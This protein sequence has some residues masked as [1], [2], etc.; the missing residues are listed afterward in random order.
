MHETICEDPPGVICVDF[1]F[2]DLLVFRI[3]RALRMMFIYRSVNLVSKTFPVFPL[4]ASNFMSRI[5]SVLRNVLLN[6]CVIFMFCSI[7]IPNLH[8]YRSAVR[9]SVVIRSVIGGVW[10]EHALQIALARRRATRVASSKRFTALFITSSLTSYF[11]PSTNLSHVSP[12][13]MSGKARVMLQKLVICFVTE[14]LLVQLP[15]PVPGPSNVVLWHEV[16]NQRL[17]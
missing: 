11:R 6:L 1:S 14:E 13:V 12:S 17:F 15:K 10:F 16:F 4:M 3:L 7:I 9:S 5:T 8:S 2:G